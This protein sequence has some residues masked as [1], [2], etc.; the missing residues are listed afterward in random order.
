M[1]KTILLVEDEAVIALSQA[2]TIQ[3]YGYTVKT[4]YSGRAAV[5]AVREEPE[6]ALVLM[7]ID[8]GRGMDGTEAASQ[9]LESRELPIV[10]LTSH[11][12]REY[13]DRVKHI[14]RY[15]YVLKNAGEFVLIEAISMAFELFDAHNQIRERERRYRESEER[16]R[17]IVEKAPEPIFVQT[18]KQFAYLNPAAVRLFG[19]E[20]AQQLIGTPVMERFHPDYHAEIRE[21][22]RLLNEE[23]V[24][25]DSRLELKFLRLDG[26]EV[27][28]DTSGVPIEYE[29]RDSALVM[30]RDL[31]EKKALRRTLEEQ[32]AYQ[33]TIL[34]S[35]DN[36]VIAVDTDGRIMRMNPTAEEL[37]GTAAA[38][39][40]GKRLS[41]VIRLVDPEQGIP[42]KDPVSRVVNSGAIAPLSEQT[43]LITGGGRELHVSDGSAPIRDGAGAI[44]GVVLVLRESTEEHRHNRIIRDQNALL[45]STFESIQDG[46]SVLDPDL[47]IR[48]VNSVMKR[49]YP[50]SIPLEGKRC[51]HAYHARAEQCSP[52][53]SL[54]CME[55]GRTETEVVAGNTRSGGE[56]W[57][58]LH[59]YPIKDPEDGGVTGVVEFVRDITARKKMEAELAA[60]ESRWRFA[61]EGAGDGVWDWNATTGTVFFSPNWKAML[62]FQDEE[63]SDSIEEW[64]SRIHP[65]DQERCF[66]DLQEHLDGRTSYYIN[67]HRLKGRDGRYVWILDRGKVME[68]DK[69]G[70]PLRVIGTHT[71]ITRTKET[72]TQ[73]RR[74]LE[75]KDHLMRELNHR[76]KNN[77]SM[78]SS[79]IGLKTNEL[80]GQADLS[81]LQRQIEAIQR[82][83]ENL[84]RSDNITSIDFRSYC[85][86]ILDSLFSPYDAAQVTLDV[87][88]ETLQLSSRTAVTLG[89][90]VN[91]IATNAIKHGPLPQEQM[92]VT[93]RFGPH[94]TDGRLQ[95]RISNTGAPFPE[96]IDLHRSESLGLQLICA[97][98]AQLNAEIALRKAPYPEFTITFPYEPPPKERKE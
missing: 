74:A 31:S 23:K 7:D 33:R 24:P 66:A 75:E 51:F 12:E 50:D 55:S 46:I 20:S 87:E 69:E 37:T 86:E 47:T 45:E 96:H 32:E 8:L 82:V 10:F 94:S 92:T 85:T 18:A 22:I 9:I 21:R 63:I 43:L 98:A 76:I 70:A 53:P 29:G 41:E 15:G 26:S 35:I 88:I 61:L 27:W 77:L 57:L 91:E 2:R 60:S 36:A 40:E 19:T 14:T 67:E 65:E 6:I 39:A 42:V 28:V 62:G 13:V 90:I 16:F 30:V 58:E 52:C 64:S 89:L 25:V 4:V 81:D 72:E 44:S 68:R 80:G 78:V 48:Y 11:T 93:L 56:Q 38:E 49:W 59:S 84:A 73:L 17:L 97:L 1:Q 34:Q 5:E 71:N 83:H 79:L 54:R 3:S 95:L